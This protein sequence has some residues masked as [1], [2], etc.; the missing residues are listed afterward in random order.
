MVSTGGSIGLR[1]AGLHDGVLQTHL[2]TVAPRQPEAWQ[3]DPVERREAPLC[4]SAEKLGA[5]LLALAVLSGFATGLF[6]GFGLQ[7]VLGQLGRS[8]FVLDGGDQGWNAGALIIVVAAVVVLVVPTL[9]RAGAGFVL[10]LVLGGLA[11]L[12]F[13]QWLFS[14]L[15]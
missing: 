14:S 10:G 2:A 12:V 5:P 11:Q 15:R 1:G 13:F 7:Q 6:A 4:S 8:G 3:Y 9:R